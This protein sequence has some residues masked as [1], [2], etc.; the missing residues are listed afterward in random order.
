[1]LYRRLQLTSS[2]RNP[3]QQGRGGRPWDDHASFC[4]FILARTIAPLEQPAA[5]Y[6]PHPS[7]S[8]NLRK[9]KRTRVADVDGYGKA[10]DLSFL[11]SASNRSTAMHRFGKLNQAL[12]SCLALR[13]TARQRTSDRKQPPPAA[14]TPFRSP[15]RSNA[16]VRT[17][18]PNHGM[19]FSRSSNEPA[20]PR[21]GVRRSWPPRTM[22]RGRGAALSQSRR[23][24]RRRRKWL[25]K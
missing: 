21:V 22:R 23:S 19:S 9:G 25:A 11:F 14:R 13:T 8:S 24:L 17:G 6:S 4:G 15:T 7:P 3:R 12:P 20:S 2:E 16:N 10:R 18:L 5:L 1:M